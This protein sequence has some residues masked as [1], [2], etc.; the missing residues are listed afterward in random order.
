MSVNCLGL[1]NDEARLIDRGVPVDHPD[2][3]RDAESTESVT[4]HG[5]DSPG[6]AEEAFR[7]MLLYY[8]FRRAERP[9]IAKLVVAASHDLGHNVSSPTLSYSRSPSTAAACTNLAD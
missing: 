6:G 2:L 3:F 4:G 7:L 5:I 1:F 8:S 9:R